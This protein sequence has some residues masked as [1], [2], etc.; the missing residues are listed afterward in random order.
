MSIAKPRFWDY[1]IFDD[2]CN[3][4]GIEPDTPEDIKSEYEEWVKQK[5]TNR[6]AGIKV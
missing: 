5:E 6:K 2:D 3:I 4:T 1:I